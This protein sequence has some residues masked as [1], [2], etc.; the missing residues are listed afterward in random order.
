M[1][2]VMTT[3]R[4][5][6]IE[7][8]FDH[9]FIEL[10]RLVPRNPHVR[11]LILKFTGKMPGTDC[12][13]FEQVKDWVEVNCEKR[14]RPRFDA[15]SHSGSGISV[16]V[17]FSETE[18]GRSRYSVDRSSTENFELGAGELLEIILEKIAEGGSVSEVVEAIADRI[19]DEA[20]EQCSPDLDNYGNYDYSDEEATSSDNRQ[21]KFSKESIRNAV[22]QFVQQRHPELAAEL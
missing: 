7:E 8:V 20:W 13:T 4:K 14:I 17:L 19:D 2:E 15:G 3:E 22:L 11:A 5:C 12:E 18:Y 1:S 9:N 6:S 10:L 21:A 16:N